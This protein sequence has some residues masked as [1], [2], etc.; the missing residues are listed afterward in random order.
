MGRVRLARLFSRGL[1][2]ALL[3]PWCDP[4]S[5]F[6][7]GDA[8][9]R[10][11]SATPPRA[12]RRL[13]VVRLPPPPAPLGRAWWPGPG[14]AAGALFS[15][16]R[17]ALLLR[18]V[19]LSVFSRPRLSLSPGRSCRRCSGGPAS[20]ASPAVVAVAAP[21]ARR[22]GPPFAAHASPVRRSVSR[23]PP[24]GPVRSV[25]VAR[26]ASAS[27]GRPWG[28][29]PCGARPPSSRAPRQSLAAY[30]PP[31][32]S[33]PSRASPWRPP[34]GVLLSPGPGSRRPFRLPS[35]STPDPDP[36]PCRRAW[37][38]SGSGKGAAGPVLPPVRGRRPRHRRVSSARWRGPCVRLGGT[39]RS[40]VA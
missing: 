38:E 13:F 4:A 15:A 9:P 37:R 19:R 22:C 25:P 33:V 18:S 11:G 40:R 24:P 6:G 26:R 5:G 8:P 2:C 21:R 1:L 32:S 10:T 31:A 36:V 34:A 12:H 28:A 39:Q 17:S 35:P 3:R 30:R 27:L 7:S 20:A 14:A 29:E 16:S 23:S